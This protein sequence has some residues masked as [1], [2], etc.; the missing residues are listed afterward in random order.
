MCCVVQSYT[1]TGKKLRHNYKR[2]SET[3]YTNERER[4]RPRGRQQSLDDDER[5]TKFCRVKSE[6]Q[7]PKLGELR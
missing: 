1:H 4:T 6:V 2:V 3:F 5:K 7:A